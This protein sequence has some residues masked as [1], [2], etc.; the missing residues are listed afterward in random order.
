MTELLQQTRIIDPISENDQLADVLIQNGEIVLVAA[1]ISDFPPD[2][3]IHDCRGLVLGTGL[4]D[5]YSHSGEPGYEERETLDSLLKS[6]ASGGFTRIGILPDTSPTVDNPAAVIQLHQSWMKHQQHFS[7]IPS[8]HIWGA[9][10]RDVTGQQLTELGELAT[11]GIIGFADGQPLDNLSLVRRALEYLQ[12]LNKPAA[13]FACDRQ[14]RA[15]GIM[16]EGVDAVRFGLPLTPIAAESSAI[17]SLLELVAATGTQVHI[18]RVSTARGVELILDAK[19]RGLPVTAST[20]WMHLLLD[21]KALKS[22]HPSLRLEPPLGNYSDMLALRKAVKTGILD[23]I[24]IDHS[25]Y[26]YEEKTVAFA[27]APPG[28]IGYELA[29][30]LLWQNLVETGEF[31]ALELWQALSKRP[32]DCL[33]QGIDGIS[34]GKKAELVLFNPQESW[35]VESRNLQTLSANSFWYG[36]DLQGKVIKIWC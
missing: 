25:P 36:Q 12:P 1:N 24:A 21:T 31:T 3:Q 33:Q 35:K 32:A 15:N 13:F 34:A 16:R 29:L 30:P 18:M 4:I 27:D 19:S 26:T 11:A 9:I 17:A 23:A 7:P 28:A 6:A 10:T 14:L 20:T 5:L 22:Y 8:L 2:T